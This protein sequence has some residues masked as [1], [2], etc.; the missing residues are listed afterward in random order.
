MHT[1]GYFILG[2]A[3]HSRTGSYGFGNSICV[4]AIHLEDQ[5]ADSIIDREDHLAI[6]NMSTRVVTVKTKEEV[7]KLK[8]EQ[9]NKR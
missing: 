2:D 3:I 1:R 6:L 8:E 4:D 7:K 9:L 5:R